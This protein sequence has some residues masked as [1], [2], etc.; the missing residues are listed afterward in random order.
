[1][2]LRT[3]SFLFFALALKVSAMLLPEQRVHCVTEYTFI[4]ST[5]EP[6]VIIHLMT[7]VCC[8]RTTV[9]DSL[10]DTY[11][12]LGYRFKF[13]EGR[14][15][16]LKEALGRYIG[17][18]AE[19]GEMIGNFRGCIFLEELSRRDF[20]KL[21]GIQIKL[22]AQGYRWSVDARDEV[23][24]GYDVFDPEILLP[25]TIEPSLLSLSKPT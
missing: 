6:V 21:P 17:N 10:L 7:A 15:V 9:F 20:D 18:Y 8:D 14:D 1:M 24:G 4:T 12:R 22:K 3:T 5:L 13:Y 11:L 19:V 25:I 16:R 2:Q 23:E